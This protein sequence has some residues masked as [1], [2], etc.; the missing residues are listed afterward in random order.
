M[1]IGNLAALA[2]ISKY[3]F[4]CSHNTVHVTALFEETELLT[5][6]EL[7]DDVERIVLEPGLVT[8]STTMQRL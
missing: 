1:H 8:V 7:A 6:S 4:Y 3:S 2:G 5:E